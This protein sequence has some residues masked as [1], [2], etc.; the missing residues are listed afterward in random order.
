M[1]NEW[2]MNIETAWTL[3]ERSIDKKRVLPV[4]FKLDVNCF[5][6]I[7]HKYPPVGKFEIYQV[8]SIALW[9]PEEA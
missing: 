3:V 2:I 4:F 6:K 9:F 8:N 7:F 5:T 1:T